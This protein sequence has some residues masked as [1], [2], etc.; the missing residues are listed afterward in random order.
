[1]YPPYQAKQGKLG[2]DPVLPGFEISKVSNQLDEDGN[3]T[4]SFVSQTPTR[5]TFFTP[6]PDQKIRGISALVDAD[7]RTIQRWIKTSNGASSVSAMDSIKEAFEQYKGKA[8]PLPCPTDTQEDLLTAYIIGDHH[9]GLY[10][11]GDETGE[12]YNLKIGE[13]LLKDT[14]FELVACSPPAATGLV[15]SLGD[16][17]HTDNSLNLTPKSKNMVDLDTRRARVYQVGVELMIACI[18]LALQKHK[19]VLVRCLPGNHGPDTTPTLAIALWA[20]FHNEPRVDIDC[21]PD[22]FF[23]H[24]HGLT[25]VGATHGDECKIMNMPGVMAARQ[26][27][28]WGATRFRYALAGHIHHK[29]KIAK[30]CYG[31][32]CETFQVLPPRDAWHHGMGFTA[33]RSMTS[34]N[35]H[36]KFGERSRNIVSVPPLA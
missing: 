1:L 34:I 16:F 27:D 6:D 21:S 30:E 3:V 33:G 14:M 28:M 36:A 7:G 2:Y 12:N 24:Q 17:F 20:F 13:K 5:G 22:R 18:E 31:V 35:Y 26:P 15:L 11:W 9:L 32:I 25:M 19:K 8:E 10:C 4:K 29:E 23:F